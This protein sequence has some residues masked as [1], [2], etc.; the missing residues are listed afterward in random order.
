MADAD[1]NVSPT[2]AMAEA[3]SGAKSKTV[4]APAPSGASPPASDLQVFE[5]VKFHVPYTI[6]MPARPQDQPLIR[7][8]IDTV[9]DECDR[10][11]NPFNPTSEISM[12]SSLPAGVEYP[13][14][15]PMEEVL[16]WADRLHE[17]SRGKFDPTVK[18]LAD[19]W[20]N[21]LREGCEPTPAVLAELEA[22][23]G[24][25][26]VTISAGH[27]TKR[28]DHVSLDLCGIAKGWCVDAIIRLLSE[29]GY[30]HLYVDWGGDVRARGWHP[31]GREWAA[32]LNTPSGL[33]DPFDPSYA[34][35][36]FDPSDTMQRV[37]LPECA[38]ATSGD[39]MQ[40][41]S[42]GYTHIFD[43][44]LKRPLKVRTH[45]VSS[46]SVQCR[47]CLMADALATIVCILGNNDGAGDLQACL[48]WLQEVRGKTEL[49][50]FY[51]YCRDAWPPANL[52]D[53]HNGIIARPV[54][55]GLLVHGTVP[56]PRSLKPDKTSLKL[57]DWLRLMPHGVAVITALAPETN[58][59]TR[60]HAVTYSSVVPLFEG[61]GRPG[62]TICFNVLNPS[63]LH[64]LLMDS[65]LTLCV[66][67]LLSTNAAHVQRFVH[68]AGLQDL[69]LTY[70]STHHT[71][72]IN[73][74]SAHAYHC[75]V[76]QLEPAG[77]HMLVV[78]EVLDAVDPR[79]DPNSC[80]TPSPGL[81]P[82]VPPPLVYC[83]G[84]YFQPQPDK[85]AEADMQAPVVVTH[86]G[87]YPVVG[88]SCTACSLDPPM[89]SLVI[90]VGVEGCTVTGKF[91]VHLP[92]RKQHSKVEQFRDL[93][94]NPWAAMYA[95]PGHQAVDEC[96][97]NGHV[98]CELHSVLP[99]P[100]RRP[101]HYLVVGTVIDVVVHSAELPLVWLGGQPCS[102][103]PPEP[104]VRRGSLAA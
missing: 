49:I 8:L 34:L 72:A 22:I 4:T 75:K 24:W 2:Q 55:G 52:R 21:S 56:P 93:A 70:H 100:T 68:S 60:A 82:D 18:P 95:M 51:L 67:L 29:H 88:Y 48:D 102:L 46:V 6:R 31:D 9:F 83:S 98:E 53:G 7:D 89:I 97:T 17:W 101:G 61:R 57:K 35:H 86:K 91:H 38:L 62:A 25:D 44:L 99:V 90:P 92:K 23:I 69:A 42:N 40:A 80:P 13:L 66:H 19:L 65:S 87:K 59:P 14:S 81:G 77:D 45:T 36:P 30:Q 32:A 54:K 39:Y 94:S 71:V 26:K 15:D 11:F 79:S 104:H 28:H 84:S 85:K 16:H 27:L 64:S 41:L 33:V 47:T 73:A 1:S 50:N 76:A 43:P 3:A 58:E 5:G 20:K 12:I 103:A 74:L 10:V 96:D 78:A 37:D 63:R